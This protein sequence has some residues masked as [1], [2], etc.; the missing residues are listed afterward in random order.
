MIV[1]PIFIFLEM[2]QMGELWFGVGD[3]DKNQVVAAPWIGTLHSFLPNKTPHFFCGSGSFAFLQ[4][5]I[6]FISK[7]SSNINIL[8]RG[9]AIIFL[10]LE[11]II[12]DIWIFF[13]IYVNPLRFKLE[14]WSPFFYKKALIWQ[15]WRKGL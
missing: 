1:D 5:F 8:N 9:I 4:L 7:F 6:C 3:E 14:I 12:I 10:T 2:I 15:T 13:I 11:K